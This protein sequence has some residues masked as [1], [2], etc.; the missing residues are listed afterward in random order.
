[1]INHK[2]LVDILNAINLAVQEK[3]LMP[4]RCGMETVVSLALQYGK[5][6]KLR[7]SEVVKVM[8]N[9]LDSLLRTQP[10]D[11]PMV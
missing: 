5:R 3:V 4:E 11:D 9:P 2:R 1:M 7:E 8:S 6:Y 10:D